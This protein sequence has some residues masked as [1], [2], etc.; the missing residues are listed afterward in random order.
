[1]GRERRVGEVVQGS[2]SRCGQRVRHDRFHDRASS[3]T[4]RRRS[5]KTGQNQAIGRS[6]GGLSTKIHALVDALGN[7]LLFLLTPG[8]AHDL[9]GADEFLPQMAAGTLLADKAFDADERV[10]EPL[11]AAGKTAVIPPKSSRKIQ[12]DYDKE[13]YQA[14]H[15]IEN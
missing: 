10:I 8:Q 11:H 1:M 2:G 4:Q 7:P 5:K 14:R 13:T 15:L 9:E 6:K 3:P 12:R